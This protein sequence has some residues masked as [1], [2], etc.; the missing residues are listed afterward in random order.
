VEVDRLRIYISISVCWRKS[1][2]DILYKARFIRGI[3][4]RLRSSGLIWL[5]PWSSDVESAIVID[6]TARRSS[7]GSPTEISRP[8]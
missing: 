8:Y 4:R 1:Q 6:V 3:R 5:M 7:L 2:G